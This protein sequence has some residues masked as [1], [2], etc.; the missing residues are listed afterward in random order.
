M[1]FRMNDLADALKVKPQP[2]TRAAKAPAP[3]ATG[4]D[5][6]DKAADQAT[7]GGK[8]KSGNGAAAGG[9]VD[10]LQWWGALTRQFQEIAG[11]AMK[12]VAQQAGGEGAATVM[13]DATRQAMKTAAGMTQAATDIARA[14]TPGKARTPAKK[15]ASRKAAAP[16]KKT[17]PPR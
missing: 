12:D 17:A 16:R 11:N 5:G 6:E 1:N 2:A 13:G 7:S 14:A 3:E 10:P 15:A 4:G 9:P 8:A